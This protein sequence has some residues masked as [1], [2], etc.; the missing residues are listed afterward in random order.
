MTDDLKRAPTSSRQKSPYPRLVIGHTAKL[1]DAHRKG[2][3]RVA[4][5]ANGTSLDLELVRAGF[6]NLFVMPVTVQIVAAGQDWAH[7]VFLSIRRQGE[8]ARRSCHTSSR[9]R[10]ASRR[11]AFF[12]K[13]N[14]EKTRTQTQHKESGAKWTI[15]HPHRD[16]LD[17]LPSN[18]WVRN[19]RTSIKK[20]S[21]LSD[22]ERGPVTGL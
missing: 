7:R 14:S 20:G 13:D 17:A 9:A 4:A 5:R 3:V 21:Y 19:R 16:L 6:P 12:K 15:K 18:P 10:P 22:G 1:R 2:Y 11:A 8:Q